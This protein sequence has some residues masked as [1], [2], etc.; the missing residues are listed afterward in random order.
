MNEKRLDRIGHEIMKVV[1]ESIRDMKDPRMHPLT[2]VTKVKVTNDLSFAEIF[3]SVYGTKE[4]KQDTLYAL[5]NATGYIRKSISANIDLR[6]TPEPKFSLDETMEEA[7][8]MEA[9]IRE[10]RQRDK[11]MEQ[12][13]NEQE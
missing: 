11:E 3:V 1:S 8:S 6:H 12:A 7:S 5:E 10:V 9:L 4:E 2:S 13:R